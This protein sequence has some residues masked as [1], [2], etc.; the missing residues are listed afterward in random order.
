VGHSVPVLRAN[1]VTDSST[2]SGNPLLDEESFQK[3]LAAAYVLQEHQDQQRPGEPLTQ[4]GTPHAGDAPGHQESS[5]PISATS[6]YSQTLAQIVATQEQIQRSHLPLPDAMSMIAEQTQFM[7]GASGAAIGL[8]EG[9]ELLY[10]AASGSAKSLLG[11]RT[12]VNSCLA[13]E[14][15]NHDALFYCPEVDSDS[16]VDAQLCKQ[17]GIK[18][19]IVVP[20][21]QGGKVVGSVEVHF[22]TANS[23]AEHDV[24]TC[25]L[26]AGMTAEALARAAEKNWKQALAD[27]R[28]TML[29]ALQKLKPELQRLASEPEPS[30]TVP[31][32]LHVPPLATPVAPGPNA[33]LACPECGNQLDAQQLFCGQCGSERPVPGKVQSQ[34]PWASTWHSNLAE[35][36]EALELADGKPEDDVFEPT[37][38]SFEA[39]QQPI[40]GA[41]VGDAS[42]IEADTQ[43]SSTPTGSWIAET[44]SHPW[45]SAKNAGAWLESRFGMRRAGRN[46]RASRADVYLRLA[47][48]LVVLTAGWAIWSHGNPP[49]SSTPANATRASSGTPGTVRQR[50]PPEPKLTA[51]EKLLIW[52]GIAEPP[53]APVYSGNPATQVWV[54]MHTALYYCPGSDLY[55]KTPKGKFTTQRDAQL[56]QFEPAYRRACD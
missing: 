1:T 50:K 36:Q 23:F 56:D 3:L 28:T 19:L 5:T 22:D 44:Q 10:R 27:Q 39:P 2:I 31:N 35:S 15:L 4:G 17:R 8:R 54:D 48:I 34:T 9:N 20:I 26:M 21:H 33:P 24:R 52:L 47:I 41:F 43:P 32:G 25:Q 11:T 7:T 49:V 51:S 38:R 46:K 55:G 6:D 18:A 53:P 16:R 14:C 13:A 30:S 37:T 29:N 12:A 40:R 42:T 45:N